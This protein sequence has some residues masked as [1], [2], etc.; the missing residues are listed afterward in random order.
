MMSFLKDLFCFKGRVT[1][2]GGKTHGKR[3]LTSAGLLPKWPQC[4]ALGQDQEPGTLY[5]CFIWATGAKVLGP[6]FFFDGFP[7]TPAGRWTIST[8]AVFELMF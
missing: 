2:Q 3:D 4:L 8:A 5:R 6:F 1:E 7:G